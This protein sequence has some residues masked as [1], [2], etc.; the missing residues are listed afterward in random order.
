MASSDFDKKIHAEFDNY[1]ETNVPTELEWSAVGEQIQSALDQRKKKRRIIFWWWSGISVGV[2]SLTVLLLG[3]NSKVPLELGA[4][5]IQYV[6]QGNNSSTIYIPNL[7]KPNSIQDVEVQLDSSDVQDEASSIVAQEKLP[8]LISNQEENGA[9]A[10]NRIS[11]ELLISPS[12]KTVERIPSQVAAF[13]ALSSNAIP[14]IPQQAEQI[15]LEESPIVISKNKQ[16]ELRILA[17]SNQLF[18]TKNNLTTQHLEPIWGWQAGLEVQRKWKE[19]WR[20]KIG[21]Q[22]EQIWTRFR[23]TNEREAL[24]Y[25]P[26][27]VD[28]VF[29][30]TFT[31]EQTIIRTDSVAGI[32]RQNVQQYNRFVNLQLPVMLGYQIMA[33]R[34]QLAVFGGINVG[35]QQQSNGLF[36]IDEQ[37]V[38][39]L[40][41][42]SVY[43]SGVQIRIPIKLELAYQMSEDWRLLATTQIEKSLTNWIN[44]DLWQAEQRPIL[45]QFNIGV[46]YSF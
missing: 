35:F 20:I 29:Q 23:F 3:Q 11:E 39:N 1:F 14:L 42:E 21:L 45:Y 44:S 36:T 10:D 22:Y 40:E 4:F 46:G 8:V 34:W 38:I 32:I 13:E 31:G 41:E 30:N 26:N 24:L 2:L 15:D 19:N 16:W 28:T 9:L 5:P 6:A 25:R 27:S 17:G 18:V 7:D 33:Q 43:R 37:E 12:K